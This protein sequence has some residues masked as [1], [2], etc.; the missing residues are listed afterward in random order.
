[1]EGGVM[2]TAKPTEI[3]RSTAT[4]R[5]LKK[6]RTPSTLAVLFAL[7]CLV[8]CTDSG[9][10]YDP[11]SPDFQAISPWD[12]RLRLVLTKAAYRERLKN[13]PSTENQAHANHTDPAAPEATFCEAC[14]IPEDFPAPPN[15]TVEAA[16]TESDGASHLGTK[17]SLGEW[18]VADCP[19][20]KKTFTD[21]FLLFVMIG[22]HTAVVIHD[23]SGT[24]DPV[25]LGGAI[26]GA[27][28]EAAPHQY[29]IYETDPSFSRYLQDHPSQGKIEVLDSGEYL[30]TYLHCEACD[31]TGAK[32]EGLLL[33]DSEIGL[34]NSDCT[35]THFW[36]N[37]FSSGVNLEGVDFTNAIFEDGDMDAVTFKQTILDGAVFTGSNQESF[38]NNVDFRDTSLKGLKFSGST[39]LESPV[40]EGMTLE[41]VEFTDQVQLKSPNFKGATLKDVVFSGAVEVSDADLR[42]ATLEGVIFDGPVRFTR[43]SVGQDDSG[44]CTV[45]KNT[46]LASIEF[47]IHEVGSGCSETPLF[48]GSTVQPISVDLADW[49]EV[50]WTNAVVVTEPEDYAYLKG[51]DL[52]NITFKGG[53]HVGGSPGSFRYGALGGA[54]RSG[55]HPGS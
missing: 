10:H 28:A 50:N 49:P 44:K 8:A 31:L 26:H 6:K 35:G 24:H 55:K 3:C 34:R 51:A 41:G 43:T 33:S 54:P 4:H 21:L 25:F 1:M 22:D 48:P 2:N 15:H 38:L 27:G 5:T 17:M 30:W 7:T 13:N 18:T 9:S 16:G 45:I 23:M 29:I 11:P 47:H 52:S 53:R 40:F 12:T 37:T 20:L 46:N 36:Q 32:V 39:V 19:N 42:G 14:L